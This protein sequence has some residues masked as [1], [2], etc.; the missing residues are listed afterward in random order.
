MKQKSFE[1]NN[2]HLVLR[3]E[4]NT[5]PIVPTLEKNRNFRKYPILN[6]KH[7]INL[8]S[9]QVCQCRNLSRTVGS[10]WQYKT[11]TSLKLKLNLKLNFKYFQSQGQDPSE[12][13]WEENDVL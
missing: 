8:E 5:P 1:N 12:W 10:V 13:A 2:V 6:P 4:K 9:G 3:K 7:L 11:K